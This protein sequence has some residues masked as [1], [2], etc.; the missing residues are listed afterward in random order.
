MRVVEA[1]AGI[2]RAVPIP[3]QRDRLTPIGLSVAE[4]ILGIA[5]GQRTGQ[6]EIRVAR[7]VEAAFQCGP[8]GNLLTVPLVS[9]AT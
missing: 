5:R 8:S 1:S 4:G 2:S 7:V 3:D 9:L 6:V